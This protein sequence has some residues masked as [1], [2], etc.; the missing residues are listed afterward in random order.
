MSAS[1]LVIRTANQPITRPHEDSVNTELILSFL[2]ESSFI[3][4]LL[5]KHIFLLRCILVWMSH[6]GC[7]WVGPDCCRP[8]VL[9][10]TGSLWRQRPDPDSNWLTGLRTRHKH[11]NPPHPPYHPPPMLHIWLT[12]SLYCRIDC[13]LIVSSLWQRGDLYQIY[14][15]ADPGWKFLFDFKLSLATRGLRLC[16]WA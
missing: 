8:D 12:L 4:R 9:R 7:V 11:T 5:S 3:L 13:E 6:G 16:W 10:C 15:R 1:V 14:I 2:I